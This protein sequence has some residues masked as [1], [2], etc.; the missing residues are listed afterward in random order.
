MTT[1]LTGT[2]LREA[3]A[4]RVMGWKPRH[5]ADKCDGVNIIRCGACGAYGHAN[6]YGRVYGRD[7]TGETQVLCADNPCCEDAAIP[8]YESDIAAAWLVVEAMRARGWAW[9]G[10]STPSEHRF[11]FFRENEVVGVTQFA[12][13]SVDG[14]L[15][16]FAGA[17]PYAICLAAIAAM[18]ASK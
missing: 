4:T 16:Q 17:V 5:R 2:A 18:E 9:Q 15:Y 8:A 12:N 7:V 14:S 1:K 10:N 13:D 6:C 3:V 11:R